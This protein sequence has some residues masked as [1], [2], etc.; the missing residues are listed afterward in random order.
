MG[1]LHHGA[2]VLGAEKSKECMIHTSQACDVNTIARCTFA[3]SWQGDTLQYV[4]K[5]CTRENKGICK[6]KRNHGL[7][8]WNL[9]P[10][11]NEEGVIWKDMGKE[12]P[13]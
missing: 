5:K 12:N 8:I 10:Y 7:H 4:C 1:K 6:E 9:G 13:K 11:L 3:H 2:W